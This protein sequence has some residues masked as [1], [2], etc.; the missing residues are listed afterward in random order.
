MKSFIALIFFIVCVE[1]LIIA[2]PCYPQAFTVTDLGTL[3]GSLNYAAALNASG[4]VTGI[5][6]VTDNGINHAYRTA[7]NQP[8]NRDTD[9]LGTLSCCQISHG[10]AIND[11]GQVA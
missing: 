5:S 3:G 7:P 6:S 1:F 4:Q 9:D 8:I 11:A 2:T 10:F